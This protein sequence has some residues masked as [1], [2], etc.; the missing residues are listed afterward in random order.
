MTGAATITPS[1][2]SSG[3]LPVNGLDLYH[4][5][6]GELG[7]SP[8]LLLLPGAFMAAGSMAAWAARMVSVSAPVLTWAVTGAWPRPAMPFDT[9]YAQPAWSDPLGL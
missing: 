8:P 4:E 5:M 6:Y 1:P 9:A 2:T 7:T 3:H